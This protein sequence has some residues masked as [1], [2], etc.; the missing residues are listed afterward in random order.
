MDN[1]IILSSQLI[2]GN[3]YRSGIVRPKA[4]P[5]ELKKA[6]GRTPVLDVGT[7]AMIRSGK[8]KVNYKSVPFSCSC[9]FLYEIFNLLEA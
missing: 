6:A 4:G 9:R 5:L 7:I 3:T 1:F 8:I 2:L